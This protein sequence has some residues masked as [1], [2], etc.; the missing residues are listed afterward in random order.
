MGKDDMTKTAYE[1]IEE[2]RDR[3]REERDGFANGQEQLQ[4]INFDLLDNI[5]KYAGERLT[6]REEVRELK[7]CITTVD[8]LLHYYGSTDQEL[9]QAKE[10]IKPCLIERETA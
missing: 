4:H 10:T 8:R 7:E 5:K 1:Q 6:L 2:E 3:L 9:R